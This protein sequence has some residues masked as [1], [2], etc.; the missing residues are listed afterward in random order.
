MIT[1]WNP[2]TQV[3]EKVNG[4]NVSPTE[5]LLNI[6]IEMRVQSVILSAMNQDVL[7]DEVENIRADVANDS[8]NFVTGP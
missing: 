2:T 4:D 6:L 1:L 5:M 7:K 8:N 3:F